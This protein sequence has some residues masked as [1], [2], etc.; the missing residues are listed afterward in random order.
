MVVSVDSEEIFVID[1]LPPNLFESHT[2]SFEMQMTL[3]NTMCGH[4][5][6][7]SSTWWLFQFRIIPSE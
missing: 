2:L 3:N 7:Q 1:N 5:Q 4:L 6:L